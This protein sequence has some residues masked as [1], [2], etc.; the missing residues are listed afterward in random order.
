M[1]CAFLLV[2][3]L[4]FSSSA[5]AATAADKM[6]KTVEYEP[7]EVLL[8]GRLMTRV[9]PGPP[10]YESVARGDRAHRVLVLK[11]DHPVDVRNS[12]YPEDDQ[13][14][15]HIM[16]VSAGSTGDSKEESAL[17]DLLVSAAGQNVVVKARLSVALVGSQ[18]TPVIAEI[19]QLKKKGARD[20]TVLPRLTEREKAEAEAQRLADREKL[21]SEVTI[22]DGAAPEADFSGYTRF[23]GKLVERRSPPSSRW[24]SWV[25]DDVKVC[26]ILQ[27]DHPIT[28]HE[29]RASGMREAITVHELDVLFP[30]DDPLAKRDLQALGVTAADPWDP[31]CQSLF[32]KR[33]AVTGRLFANSRF[34]NAFAEAD[35]RVDR[36]HPAQ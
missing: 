7:A 10:N 6:A 24:D 36:I 17:K 2:L 28:I 26:W 32:G 12:R 21:L 9:F 27:L 22:V 30:F 35:L 4:A 16:Q 20:F 13:R 18:H 14:N 29:V 25:K 8:T 19:L 5:A 23:V 31:A 1:G 15:I 11:L 33:Y 34:R 3:G